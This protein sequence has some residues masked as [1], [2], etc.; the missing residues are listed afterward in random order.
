MPL[1]TR[2]YNMERIDKRVS[3]IVRFNGRGG[4]YP[5]YIN[6]SGNYVKLK[7]PDAVWKERMGRNFITHFSTTDGINRYILALN[8]ETLEWTLETLS[9]E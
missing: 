6:L 4:V 5:V 1:G 3:V 8:H 9:D 2:L 7:K